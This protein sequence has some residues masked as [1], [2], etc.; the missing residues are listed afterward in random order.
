MNHHSPCQSPLSFCWKLIS[1]DMELYRYHQY[2]CLIEASEV[3]HPITMAKRTHISFPM[4]LDSPAKSN[5][6]RQLSVEAEPTLDSS[7]RPTAKH[8]KLKNQQRPGHLTGFGEICHG[9]GSLPAHF[10]SLIKGLYGLLLLCHLSGLVRKTI[11][12]RSSSAPQETVD[13]ARVTSEP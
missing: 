3:L 12:L 13:Q 11:I 8:R 1:I 9:C 5:R 6:K 4:L 2:A 10:E 7:P